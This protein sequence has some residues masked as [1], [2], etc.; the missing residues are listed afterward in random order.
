MHYMH[1]EFPALATGLRSIEQMPSSAW[2]VQLTD[3]I[4]GQPAAPKAAAK[5]KPKAAPKAAAKGKREGTAKVEDVG[6]PDLVTMWAWLPRNR[7]TVNAKYT[8]MCWR[9]DW[10]TSI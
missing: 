3:D 4:D 7:R 5:A 9:G 10:P 2:R 1:A 6:I 8:R